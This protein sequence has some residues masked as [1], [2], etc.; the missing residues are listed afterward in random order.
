MAKFFK[1]LILVP[2]A[3]IILAFAIANRQT[4]SISVDPFSEPGASSAFLAAPLFLLLF[5]ALIVGLVIGGVATWFTQGTN[6]RRARR[7]EEEA[8]RWREEVRR[9]REQP[10]VVAAPGRD[11]V[12]GDYG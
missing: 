5:L 3:A 2:I 6:R 10:A 12:R 9:M 11:L 7:A 4:V 1:L 8:E